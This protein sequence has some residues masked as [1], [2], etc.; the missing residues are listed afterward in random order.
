M[1]S[2]RF[3]DVYILLVAGRTFSCAVETRSATFELHKIPDRACHFTELDLWQKIRPRNCLEAAVRVELRDSGVTHTTGCTRH[4]GEVEDLDWVSPPWDGE[5]RGANE[6]ARN[7]LA[8]MVTDMTTSF[9]SGRRPHLGFT[10]ANR[11][12]VAIV[13]S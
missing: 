5:E 4:V 1:T 3:R 10:I 6:V 7:L 11:K 13:L 8:F 2:E 9:R 12:P